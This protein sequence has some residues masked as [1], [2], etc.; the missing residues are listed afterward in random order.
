MAR[1]VCA[2][3]VLAP[4][5]E[6]PWL[7][8][9]AELRVGALAPWRIW[10][11]VETPDDRVPGPDARPFV[12]SSLVAAMRAGLD[13]EADA[14]LDEGSRRN[15]RLWQGAFAAWRPALMSVVDIRA[16][17]SSPPRPAAGRVTAFSGGA[18][19]HFTL[20]TAAGDGLPLDAGMMAQGFDIPLG[21][22]AAFDRAF[23]RV[24]STLTASGLRAHRIRTN[25]RELDRACHLSWQHETHGPYLA[26]ALACLSPWYGSAVIPS[27]FGHE[28][29]VLPWASNALTDPLLGGE[30][31]GVIHHG[32][33]RMRIDKLF[34]L[35]T[36]G[37]FARSARVC[38]LNGDK[39]A[40]CGRC[41]KCATLQLAFWVSGIP[42][43]AAFPTKA[44]LAD[45]ARMRLP[46]PSYRHTFRV[47]AGRA[48]AAGLAEVAASLRAALEQAGGGDG[49]AGRR[50]LGWL[51]RLPMR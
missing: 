9:E 37:S 3:R 10:F 35:A 19:S 23:R 28:H 43:P 38:Y 25:V 11:E 2:L 48:E 12:L 32:A 16:P 26:A 8:L 42:D 14:P 44:S 31:Q 21:D 1:P 7:R 5:R 39:D 30:G 45:L 33:E 41:Y 36:D 20:S 17:L 18:D 4:R 24:E 22:E 15:L 29:P 13:L 50:L 49:S 27:S 51:R 34:R 40:N 47:L 46:K 6:G